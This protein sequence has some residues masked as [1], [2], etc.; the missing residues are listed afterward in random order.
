MSEN[1]LEI[2][3]INGRKYTHSRYGTAMLESENDTI[4]GHLACPKCLSTEFMISYGNYSCIATC[5]CGF[6]E[7]IYSG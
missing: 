3:I 6:S 1:K 5:K 7:E 2:T 4:P